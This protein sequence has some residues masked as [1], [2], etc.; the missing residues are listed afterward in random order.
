MLKLTFGYMLADIL[1]NV[2]LESFSDY[3]LEE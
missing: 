2:A 3:M 1:N